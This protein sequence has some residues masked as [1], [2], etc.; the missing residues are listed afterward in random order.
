M[1][2]VTFVD[3]DGKT[4]LSEKQY[5]WGT[6]ANAIEQPSPSK[7][8]Y[9]FSGWVPA[10]TTVTED[11]T[12]KA[13]YSA[14]GNTPYTVEYYKQNSAGSTAFTKDTALTKNLT[15]MTGALAN[16]QQIKISGYILDAENTN[17]IFAGNIAADGSLVLKLYYKI[18]KDGNGIADDEDE[19]VINFVD[20]DNSLLSS[21]KY[22]WGTVAN[23]ITK[24]SPSRAGYTFNG[25][26]PSVAKVTAD[27]TYKATYTANSGIQYKVQYY[28]QSAVGSN[29]F[30]VDNTLTKTLKGTT[31]ETVTAQQIAISGYAFDS[32]NASNVK[33]GKV[34]AD[35]SLVLKLYYKVDKDGNGTPDDEQKYTIKFVDYDGTVL[36]SDQY[37]WGT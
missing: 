34:K 22:K 20:Y 29:S 37:I 12:Y 25:W 28:K 33:S 15:G 14:S 19:Y 1:H 13:T 17:N 5:K 36:K 3:E 11:I 8:G 2:T 21:A 31:D 10:V 16:A 27:A 18:D 6:A 35:G 26:N 23:S 32:D 4:V 24:P 9:N 30:A 7:T